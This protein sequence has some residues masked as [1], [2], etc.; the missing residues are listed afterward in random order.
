MKITTCQQ[1]KVTKVQKSHNIEQNLKLQKFAPTCGVNCSIQA[2]KYPQNVSNINNFWTKRNKKFKICTWANFVMKNANVQSKFVP[3]CD[4]TWP[5]QAQKCPKM[6]KILIKSRCNGTKSRKLVLG[7]HFGMQNS[8][9][10]SEFAKLQI[11]THL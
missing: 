1:F 11:C 5:I 10:Q 4:V 8:I 6:C 7:D 2:P 3:T 9:E